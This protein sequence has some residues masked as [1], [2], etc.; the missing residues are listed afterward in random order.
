MENA[1]QLLNL[2]QISLDPHSTKHRTGE[3]EET[4]TTT[5]TKNNANFFFLSM[6]SHIQF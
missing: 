5:T 6:E 3:A 1:Q 2:R 4:R